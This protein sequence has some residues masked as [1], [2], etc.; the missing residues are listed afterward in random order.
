[1]TLQC[2]CQNQPTTL[3]GVLLMAHLF[4][5]KLNLKTFINHALKKTSIKVKN[6]HENFKKKRNNYLTNLNKNTQKKQN[7]KV[8]MFFTH[9]GKKLKK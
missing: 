5:A 8:T 3:K 2:E 4:F 1:M 7:K 9:F 6:I